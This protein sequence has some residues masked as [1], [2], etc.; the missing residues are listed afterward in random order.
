MK[1]GEKTGKI[2]PT[3]AGG[4]PRRAVQGQCLPQVGVK[5]DKNTLTYGRGFRP[6]LQKGRGLAAS[7]FRTE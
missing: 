3:F 2:V 1:V 6:V 5:T 4:V 7:P